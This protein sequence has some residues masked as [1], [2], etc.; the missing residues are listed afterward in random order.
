MA[1]RRE[2]TSNAQPLPVHRR[3]SPLP[4]PSVRHEPTLQEHGY[5]IVYH[6]MC[7]Y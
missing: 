7:L 3:W 4:S 6:A 5:G 1:H 2:H